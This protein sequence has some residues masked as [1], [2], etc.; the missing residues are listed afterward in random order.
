[1]MGRA[2]RLHGTDGKCMKNFTWSLV[3]GEDHMG[4]V[5]YMGV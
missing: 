1:M 4:R 3:K 2:S 5:G